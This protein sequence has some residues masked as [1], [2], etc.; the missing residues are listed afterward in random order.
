MFL[1][2]CAWS[3]LHSRAQFYLFSLNSGKSQLSLD[4][5]ELAR[6]VSEA[7]SGRSGPYLYHTRLRWF[8]AA[9]VPDKSGQS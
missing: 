9:A 8:Q 7:R 2:S 1:W 5:A 6:E 3:V 4:P